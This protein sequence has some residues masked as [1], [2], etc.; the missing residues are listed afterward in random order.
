MVGWVIALHGGAGAIP[1]NLPDERR[2]PR[3]TALRHCLDLGVPP[4]NPANIHLT[5][6]NSSYASL[7][8][9]V[10][11]F[12]DSVLVKLNIEFSFTFSC[13]CILA[14]LDGYMNI[15]MDQTE[16]Y[17]NGQLKNKYGDALALRDEYFAV[18]DDEEEAAAADGERELLFFRHPSADM[19][20]TEAELDKNLIQKLAKK[21]TA[22]DLV[23]IGVGT[24][25]GAGVYI[26]VGT[27]A[28]QHTGPALAVS[29]FIAGVAAALSACC[30]AEL[31]LIVH[32]LAVLIIMLTSSWRRLTNRVA[33]IESYTCHSGHETGRSF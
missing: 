6:P 29:F 4:S 24:T 26:L 19:L 15:A 31:V 28:R 27:V 11:S 2:I 33:N 12:C 32:L 14:C 13:T 1:I 25:I 3:E 20:L 9:S 22:V 23:A 18:D 21:L 10:G 17:V 30:Y 5:S 7:S 16:E 8:L